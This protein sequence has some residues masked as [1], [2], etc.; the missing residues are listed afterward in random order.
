MGFINDLKSAWEN[1]K[2]EAR[3]EVIREF[4]AYIYGVKYK[5]AI[6]SKKWYPSQ[7]EALFNDIMDN[8]NTIRLREDKELLLDFLEFVTDVMP[9]NKIDLSKAEGYVQK[10]AERI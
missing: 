8:S 10:V 4:F 9:H 1:G 6:V 2:Q 3:M 5:D 7:Y